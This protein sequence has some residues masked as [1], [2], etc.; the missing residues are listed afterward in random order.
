MCLQNIM[1]GVDNL[2]SKLRDG[3]VVA[4]TRTY[5]VILP[6]YWPVYIWGPENQLFWIMQPVV[7]SYSY[8]ENVLTHDSQK[9]YSD[10]RHYNKLLSPLYDHKTVTFIQVQCATH[11]ASG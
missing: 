3:Y 2:I 7:S 5:T 11:Y 9:S 10:L 6:P 1:G 4:Q 8:V